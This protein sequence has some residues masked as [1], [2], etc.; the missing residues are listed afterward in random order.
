MYKCR[1]IY[2][3][4]NNRIVIILNRCEVKCQDIFTPYPLKPGMFQLENK[5]HR[6]L[7]IEI[8]AG[9]AE[10]DT[11]KNTAVCLKLKSQVPF[12]VFG[13]EKLRAGK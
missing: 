13:L 10:T 6:A 2:I 9:Q 1:I 8:G 11:R 4:L 5:V 12:D 3:M 7:K